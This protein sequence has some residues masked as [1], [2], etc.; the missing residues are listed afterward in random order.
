MSPLE[1]RGDRSWKKSDETP[2]QSAPAFQ[3][4]CITGP[5]G[6]GLVH[7]CFATRDILAARQQLCGT[8]CDFRNGS[9]RH[10]PPVA[11]PEAKSAVARKLT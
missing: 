3:F 10:R 11:E 4:N 2:A 7:I 8:R 6:S 5:T 1:G 9:I